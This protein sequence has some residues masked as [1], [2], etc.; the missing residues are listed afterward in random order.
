MRRS[1]SET[2]TV[3]GR[4]ILPTALLLSVCFFGPFFPQSEAAP[5]TITLEDYVG[6]TL[7]EDDRRDILEI[8]KVLSDKPVKKMT[9]FPMLPLST[10]SFTIVYTEEVIGTYLWDVRLKIYKRDP[11]HWRQEFL[12]SLDIVRGPW[13]TR[14]QELKQA[15]LR[16]FDISGDRL[17]LKQADELSYRE[18][19]RVLK[20]IKTRAIVWEPKDLSPDVLRFSKITA[21][22]PAQPQGSYEIHVDDFGSGF[23]VTAQMDGNRLVVKK[24]GMWIS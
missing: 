24:V 8:A 9:I 4:T 23:V 7:T 16:V 19:E 12:D 1:G 2:Y 10:P 20:A 11:T 6:I 3:E 13:A 21:V 22:L 15:M 17:I 14:R 18:I 5:P